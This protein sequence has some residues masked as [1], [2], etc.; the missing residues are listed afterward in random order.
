MSVLHVSKTS[1]PNPLNTGQGTATTVESRI[2][3]AKV[4]KSIT[5]RAD[6]ANSDDILVNRAGDAKNGFVLHAGDSTPALKVQSTDELGIVSKSGSQ[7][8]SWC[9]Q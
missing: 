6:S 8:Y 3:T 2:A 1:V 9:L 4:V 5:I 7:G